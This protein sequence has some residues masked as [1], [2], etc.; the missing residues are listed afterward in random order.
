MSWLRE[1]ERSRRRTDTWAANTPC[2]AA[3]GDL[4]WE[5]CSD[6]DILMSS[7][8]MNPPTAAR[9]VAPPQQSPPPPR[10]PNPLP[11]PPPPPKHPQSKKR[12]TARKSFAS[13]SSSSS[14]QALHRPHGK[15]KGKQAQQKR[16]EEP[17]SL[18]GE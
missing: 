5:G 12:P 7:C 11:P 10:N 15:G 18:Q 2:W 4:G 17:P 13:G 3:L 6:E 8:G 14:D 9:P 1:W 16:C